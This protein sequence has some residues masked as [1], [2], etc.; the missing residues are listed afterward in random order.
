MDTLVFDIE[1]SNF[2]TDPDVGWDNF[3]ALKI[4][5]V[6]VYSYHRA[7]YRTFEAHEMEELGRWFRS[8]GRIVGFGIN[9]YDVPVLTHY[10]K[11]TESAKDVDLW[12]KERVDLLSEIEAA[13]GGRISLSKLA[14]AN[15][16]IAKDHHGRHAIS[17]F[18]EGKLDELKAY[19]ANDVRLTKELYEKWQGGELVV[20]EK[21][22]GEL[23]PVGAK[24]FVKQETKQSGTLF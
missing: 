11:R 23:V 1:T 8:A 10:L 18:R 3:G 5:M 15:L 9:R 19:C 13:T 22:S 2:F 4:S 17:M 7:E 12:S 6:G 14:Q 16:G 21:E 20:P 24:T